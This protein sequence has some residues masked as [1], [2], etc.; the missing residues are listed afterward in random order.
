MP[1]TGLHFLLVENE[2]LIGLDVVMMLEGAGA[3]VQGPIISAHEAM[4]AVVSASSER[5]WDMAIMD[6]QL[7]EETCEPAARPLCSKHIPVVFHTGSSLRAAALSKELS[8][9]IVAKPASEADF[10]LAIESYHTKG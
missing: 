10:T 9:P 1:L 3:T 4:E 6:Y 2:P 5:A 8:I 7:G